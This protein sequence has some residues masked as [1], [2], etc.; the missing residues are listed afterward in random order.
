[1]DKWENTTRPYEGIRTLTKHKMMISIG[2]R[3]KDKGGDQ[4]DE[5]GC[6]GDGM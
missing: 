2:E 1:M 6:G 4:E 5:K 3:G